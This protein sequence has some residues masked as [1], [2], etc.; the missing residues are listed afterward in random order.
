MVL[1]KTSCCFSSAVLVSLCADIFKV[2]M[3]SSNLKMEATNLF[4]LMTFS[5]RFPFKY[6]LHGNIS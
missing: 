4:T 5:Q 3:L 6:A 1:P 2:N